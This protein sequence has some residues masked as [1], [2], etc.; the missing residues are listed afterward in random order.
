VE[1]AELVTIK[2]LLN[3]GSQIY[4][5]WKLPT[6]YGLAS[7]TANKLARSRCSGL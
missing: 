3:A 7:D 2:L 1:D 4:A 6:S 5:G